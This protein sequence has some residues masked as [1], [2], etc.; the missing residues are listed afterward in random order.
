MYKKFIYLYLVLCMWSMVAIS[1]EDLISLDSREL[2]E[3]IN[4]FHRDS[5][6]INAG[7]GIG[8]KAGGLFDWAAA[9]LS[10]D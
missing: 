4:P 5:L 6:G 7:Y 3:N 9:R 10:N 1:G 2:Q 8:F